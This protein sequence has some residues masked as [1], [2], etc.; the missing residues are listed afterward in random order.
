MRRDYAVHAQFGEALVPR[1]E[2]SRL[3][4]FIPGAHALAIVSPLAPLTLSTVVAALL[5]LN[6]LS[7]RPPSRA[8]LPPTLLQLL[9]LGLSVASGMGTI[10]TCTTQGYMRVMARAPS[11]GVLWCWTVVRLDLGWAVAALAGV[12]AGMWLTGEAD[13]VRAL[14]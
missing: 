5:L 11:L 10:H 2:L 3:A 8:P 12:G 14:M 6:F 13:W 1:Q 9:L 4:N 7:L